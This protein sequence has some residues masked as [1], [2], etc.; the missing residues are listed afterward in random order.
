MEGS[1]FIP[2]ATFEGPK[3]G[4]AFKA[5]QYGVG[6]YKDCSTTSDT[7]STDHSTTPH[8][9]LN[10][11]TESAESE[12]HAGVIEGRRKEFE[13]FN[14]QS[15]EFCRLGYIPLTLDGGVLKKVVRKSCDAR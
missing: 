3:P 5:E 13:P 14:F 4:Y 8:E 2:S 1:P 6:Y 15:C 11:N 9:A 10:E 7:V 12:A